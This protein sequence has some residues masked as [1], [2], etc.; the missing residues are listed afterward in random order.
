ME[1]SL[2]SIVV[3][4]YVRL[5]DLR[6]VDCIWLPTTPPPQ[7]PVGF[8]QWEVMESGAAAPY[9]LGASLPPNTPAPALLRSVMDRAVADGMSFMRA[10]GHGVHNETELQTAPG[11]YREG[12]F[13]GL[14]YALSEARA[15]GL[16]VIIPLGTHWLPVGGVPQYATWAG[17]SSS[18]AFYSDA[19]AR[20]LYK[21]HVQAVLQRVNAINGIAYKDD[22]TIFAWYAIFHHLAADCILWLLML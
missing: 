1:G 3:C 13:A 12:M 6:S 10:W 5:F 4:G 8:N 18:S 7:K 17:L 14:D 19:T 20:K 22:P 16:K 2:S 15:R 11:V 21:D 9:L